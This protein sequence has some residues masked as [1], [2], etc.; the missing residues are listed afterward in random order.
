MIVSRQRVVA[1][2][3]QLRQKGAVH[4]H[5][6]VGHSVPRKMLD[7]AFT[8]ASAHDAGELLI[9]MEFPKRRA[10]SI[11]IILAN[12]ES[13]D[14]VGDDLAHS[15]CRG[16]HRRNATRHALEE[17]LTKELRHLGDLSIAVSSNAGKGYTQGVSIHGHEHLLAHRSVNGDVAPFREP[18]EVS[19]VP[20]IDEGADNVQAD[21]GRQSAYQVVHSL[22][23]EHT[24]HEKRAV[25]IAQPRARLKAIDVDATEDDS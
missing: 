15:P 22:M 7:D 20:L 19:G 21:P 8:A 9:P 5:A 1:E 23:W 11:W 10:E 16:A 12:H 3:R 13:R 2:R 6:A 17:G 14:A 18:P 25:P 4:A 24:S